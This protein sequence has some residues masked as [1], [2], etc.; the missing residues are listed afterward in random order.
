MGEVIL[1]ILAQAVGID[2]FLTEDVQRVRQSVDEGL[3]LWGINDV[4]L[5]HVHA[6][7]LLF[8]Q[9]D[10]I[11]H[12]PI[13]VVVCFGL[14]QTVHHRSL[15]LLEGVG[16]RAVWSQILGHGLS[17][18]FVHM[19]IDLLNQTGNR[20]ENG[21]EFCTLFLEEISQQTVLL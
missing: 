13:L 4:D 8:L 19:G 21:C 17:R 14:F 18:F 16:E 6:I 2:A 1:Q 5:W 11:G 10:R 12:V 9:V 15:H 20:L 3:E 7:Q